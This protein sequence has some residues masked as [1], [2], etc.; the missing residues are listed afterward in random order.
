MGDLLY[1]L[2][3]KNEH[4]YDLLFEFRNFQKTI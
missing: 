4:D 3:R 1:I 2:S